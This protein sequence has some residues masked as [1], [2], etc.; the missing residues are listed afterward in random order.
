VRAPQRPAQ[1]LSTA[2]LQLALDRLEDEAAAVRLPAVDL[3]DEIGRQ[4]T[5][6]RSVV[7]M[8]YSV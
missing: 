8:S 2:P 7:T 5:V 3:F 6:T 1:L 4:R